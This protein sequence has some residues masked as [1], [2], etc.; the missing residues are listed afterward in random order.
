MEE[1]I[2]NII[3][4]AGAFLVG[5]VFTKLLIDAIIAIG[6]I[7][8]AKIKQYLGKHVALT[9]RGVMTLVVAD[10]KREAGENRTVVTLAAYDA[11]KNKVGKVKV[12][13]DKVGVSIGDQIAMA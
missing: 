6:E 10:M 8:A 3:I 5:L 9:S 11:N 7:T 2:G 12:S 13:G 4:G 1:F